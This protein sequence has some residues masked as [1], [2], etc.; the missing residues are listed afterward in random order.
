[1]AVAVLAGFLPTMVRFARDRAWYYM[2]YTRA[3]RE[4][5]P[6]HEGVSKALNVHAAVGLLWVVATFL[7]VG[8][9]ATGGKGDARRAW[10]RFSGK[11]VMP[12]IMFTQIGSAVYYSIANFGTR[13]ST[14][15][16][17]FTV[18]VALMMLLLLF[19]GIQARAA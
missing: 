8:S 1:M 10:H 18:F 12:A 4:E 17:V 19:H 3:M 16:L 9:G 7:Q 2:P 11:V 6:A 14:V 15:K 13:V 5:C